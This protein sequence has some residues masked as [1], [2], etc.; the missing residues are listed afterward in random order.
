MIQDDMLQKFDVPKYIKYLSVIY[1]AISIATGT[2]SL[3]LKI[4]EEGRATLDQLSYITMMLRNTVE[5]FIFWGVGRVFA[6]FTEE[7]K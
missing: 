3:I 5:G 2:I 7:N 6:K 1:I 4:L